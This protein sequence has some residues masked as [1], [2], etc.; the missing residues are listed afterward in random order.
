M[1]G[2]VWLGP[3]HDLKTD[4]VNTALLGGSGTCSLRN[5]IL[6]L[7]PH[8]PNCKLKVMNA[9]R[10]SLWTLLRSGGRLSRLIKEGRGRD[11]R[12]MPH[13]P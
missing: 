10:A 1:I 4:E 6:A 12:Q 11:A 2:L 7:T 8:N 3:N 13:L 9:I 5:Y